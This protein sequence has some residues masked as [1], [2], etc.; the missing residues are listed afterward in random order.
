[1]LCTTT[2]RGLEESVGDSL[3]SHSHRLCG[4]SDA[5]WSNA[6][7]SGRSCTRPQSL[8]RSHFIPTLP[9][10]YCRFFQQPPSCHACLSRPPRTRLLGRRLQ[11]RTVQPADA[12]SMEPAHPARLGIPHRLVHLHNVDRHQYHST[13]LHL[14][15]ARLGWQHVQRHVPLHYEWRELDAHWRHWCQYQQCWRRHVH[16]LTASDNVQ[17][18]R[19]GLLQGTPPTQRSTLSPCA[20]TCYVLTLAARSAPTSPCGVVSCLWLANRRMTR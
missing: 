9:L 4:M 15:R 3:L 10:W 8:S 12:A 7:Y 1:M 17:L 18:R 19:L 5:Q 6:S 14:Q 20:E 11:R 2:V 16:R 13:G